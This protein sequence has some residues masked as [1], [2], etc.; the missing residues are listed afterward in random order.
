MCSETPVVALTSFFGMQM[1]PDPNSC[2][3][4]LPHRASGADNFYQATADVH[5]DTRVS[6][7]DGIVYDFTSPVSA[8]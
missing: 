5:G 1:Y 2:P 8:T 7:A 3:N 6:G 4:I